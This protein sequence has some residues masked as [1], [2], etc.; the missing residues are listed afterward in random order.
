[1]SMIAYVCICMTPYSRV[2]LIILQNTQPCATSFFKQR[3]AYMYRGRQHREQ[4]LRHVHKVANPARMGV[5]RAFV[6][7]LVFQWSD[8][9]HAAEG[10]GFDSFN[11]MYSCRVFSGYGAG[12]FSSGSEEEEED[13]EGNGSDEE[14]VMGIEEPRDINASSSRLPDRWDVL[15]LGQAM[16]P[17]RS[18]INED[19]FL[20]S[21]PIILLSNKYTIEL[22]LRSTE[23]SNSLPLIE[24]RL[25][26]LKPSN[27][28]YHRASPEAYE[29]LEQSPLNRGSARLLSLEPLNKVHHR[30]SHETYG[31]LEQSPFNRGS[32][33]FSRALKQSTPQSLP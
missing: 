10:R 20:D 16:L 4:R 23:L 33:P 14:F 9:G 19:V 32:T 18:H 13:E 30:N 12:E 25:L 27:K 1:M 2:L 11:A 21:L 24:A 31:A 15:G 26:S 17:K 3:K 6:I 5:D 7:K 29:A 28:V 22:L 8:G